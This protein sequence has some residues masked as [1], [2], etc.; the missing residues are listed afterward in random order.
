MKQRKPE[1]EPET[2]DQESK[3]GAPKW[4]LTF[5]D[6]L[7]LLLTFFVLMYSFSRPEQSTLEA[8]VE[9][10]NE[11]RS[12]GGVQQAL[13]NETNLVPEERRLLSGRVTTSGAEN[14]PV[15]REV[16]LEKLRSFHEEL[17]L[18]QLPE[19]GKALSIRIPLSR[20]FGDRGNTL[21]GDGKAVVDRAAKILAPRRCTLT[22][23]VRPGPARRS[24]GIEP[25]RLAVRI[26]QRLRKRVPSEYVDLCISND[27]NLRGLRPRPGQC[28]LLILAE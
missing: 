6:S 13:Q 8:L 2:P 12:A 3:A 7:T 25:A 14:P 9:A 5:G 27:L 26:V 23:S 28:L 19:L 18:E 4:M 11:G 16:E 24:D 1:S 17:D 15:Y 20:L 10:L 22:V 21:T